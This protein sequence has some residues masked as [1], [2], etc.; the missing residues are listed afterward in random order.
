[1]LTPASNALSELG[2]ATVGHLAVEIG[3]DRESLHAALAYWVNRGDVRARLLTVA[4]G[5]TRT[6]RLSHERNGPAPG[7][8][9]RT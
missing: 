7:H 1:M 3:T 6:G 8:N 9:T 2:S 5:E 4:C